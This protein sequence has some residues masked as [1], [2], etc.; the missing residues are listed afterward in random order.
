VCSRAAIFR[1]LAWIVAKYEKV[2]FVTVSRLSKIQIENI[3]QKIQHLIF[4]L[5]QGRVARVC[6][7]AT[8]PS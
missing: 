2:H 8:L 4:L 1:A 3:S 6:K 5:E 7:R